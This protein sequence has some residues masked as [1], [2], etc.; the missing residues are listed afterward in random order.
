MESIK[1]NDVNL[2]YDLKH[3]TQTTHL[4]VGPVQDDEALFL[5]GLVKTV[6]PKTVIEFGYYQGYSSY[7]F[8]KALDED[9]KLYSYDI[10]PKTPHNDK[11]F[12]FHQKS[13]TDFI[14][15]DVDN[16]KIDLV[17]FDSVHYMKL[18][19]ITYEKLKN[20]LAPNAIIVI[21]DTGLHFIDRFNEQK[22]HGKCTSCDFENHCGYAHQPGERKF[23]NWMLSTYPDWS[24]IE[25]HSFSIMRH[26]LTILQRKYNLS[27]ADD[28][29]AI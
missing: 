14:F 19:T 5:F 29:Q 27:L 1:K 28:C 10:N 3:L 4:V 21:H 15:S 13:Q 23:V 7:N 22:K 6:R 25:L 12:K 26:G 2:K 24:V 16:R 17:F 18:N 11:R 8:L 9:A 20:Y